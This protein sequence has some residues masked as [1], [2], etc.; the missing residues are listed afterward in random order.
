LTVMSIQKVISKHMYIK[1][2]FCA[3][4]IV[5]FPVA[6]AQAAGQW[7]KQ[8]DFYFLTKKTRDNFS[9]TAAGANKFG[10]KYLK[11]DGIDFLVRGANDWN[12]YGRLNLGNSNFF[13]VPIRVGMKVDQLHF[14]VGG[15]VGNSYEKDKLLRLYGDNYYYATLTLIFV[16]QDDVYKSLSVPVFWDWFHLTASKWSKNGASIRSLG[17]NPVRKDCSMF[18]VVFTN[19]RPAEPLKK[20]LVMDSWLSDRPFSE[21]FAATLESQD[22]LESSPK[23]DRQFIAAVNNAAQEPADNR[24]EWLFNNDLDGWISGCSENWSSDASWQAERFG[25]KGIVVIPA[26]NV[27][28]DKFS[29]IEKKITLP[30]WQT[31][32]LKFLRHSA[33]YSELSKQWT[34]GLL[35]VIVKAGAGQEK[36]FEKLYSGEWISEAVDLSQY[37]NKTVIIRFEN[38]GAG[39]VQL[40]NST[41]SLCDGE[42]AIIDDIRLI[43]D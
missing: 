19:P 39:Q 11:Y 17:N 34:D 18:H 6:A 16:Y 4:L 12:D 8:G 13:S 14:L 24:S 21:V 43:R 10:S 22:T 31:L 32:G 40:T 1:K 42:D 36:V 30:D 26:C 23:E 5:L 38:H 15:N 27:A 28:G 9:A 3:A 29:W 25:R 41:S 7:E 20:I 37:K 2:I 35:R 33:E